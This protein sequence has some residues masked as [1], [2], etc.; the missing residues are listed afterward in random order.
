M[1]G[2]GGRGGFGGGDGGDS[3]TAGGGQAGAATG[4]MRSNPFIRLVADLMAR[5]MVPVTVDAA[6][7]ARLLALAAVVVVAVVVVV[8][9]MGG[10]D[11][12]SFGCDPPLHSP[13]GLPR[14]NPL[15]LFDNSRQALLMDD[16]TNLYV[17]CQRRAPVA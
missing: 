7:P 16:I 4:P 12:A 10:D 3:V 11:D 8:I 1:S 13:A 5:E 2:G 6:P 14:R 9:V 17:R 15:M